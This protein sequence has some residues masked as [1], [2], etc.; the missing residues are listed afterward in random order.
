MEG[1]HIV[2]NSV[3]KCFTN[4]VIIWL[5]SCYCCKEAYDH[6]HKLNWTEN[7]AKICITENLPNRFVIKP[8]DL[9]LKYMS[10]KLYLVFYIRSQWERYQIFSFH[11]PFKVL[12]Q[13]FFQASTNFTNQWIWCCIKLTFSSCWIILS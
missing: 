11:Y 9:R 8:T 3:L 10:S 7:I 13:F 1:G 6:C 4:S 12:S 5:N 2:K